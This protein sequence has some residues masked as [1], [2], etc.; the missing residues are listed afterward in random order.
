MLYFV[1]FFFDIALFR[2]KFKKKMDKMLFVKGKVE[3]FFEIVN[4]T[5]NKK[6]LFMCCFITFSNK[7]KNI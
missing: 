5:I 3:V 7:D 6:E 1:R 2:N 4:I